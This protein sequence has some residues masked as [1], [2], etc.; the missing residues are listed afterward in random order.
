MTPCPAC[1]VPISAE[2]S[3]CPK[4]GHVLRDA[5][6]HAMQPCK[7]CGTSLDVDSLTQTRSGP[8]FVN[9]QQADGFAGVAYLPCPNCGDPQPFGDSER[10]K[11]IFLIGGFVLVAAIAAAFV[12][13]S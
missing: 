6:A 5:T 1:A 10:G 12:L 9:Q 4:C 2:A 7:T 3:A 8:T 13:L 11:Y